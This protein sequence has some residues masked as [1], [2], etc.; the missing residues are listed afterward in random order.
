M[1]NDRVERRL[2]AVL[3]ADVVEYSRLMG[4]DEV[5][6][7]ARFNGALD[8]VIRPAIAGHQGRLVKT[9]GDGLLVEFASVVDAI[10]CAVKI[11]DQ[12][13]H[14]EKGK[15]NPMLLRIGVNLG[16]IIVEG[17]D[18][19]G[20]GVNIAARLEALA[21]PGGIC[22]SRSARDQVR[23]KLAY[24]IDDMGEVEVNN[25]ARP[26]RAFQI[27]DGPAEAT[28]GITRVATDSP[29]QAPQ[30]HRW[31]LVSAVAV[32]LAIAAAA[33]VWFE[34]WTPRV[35]AAS[36]DKM[37]FALPDKPSVA[38][39]PFDVTSNGDGDREF[40]DAVN[41]DLTRGLDRVSG[42][43]VIARSSTLGYVGEKASPAKVAEDLGVQHVVRASLRRA[44]NR[45]RIDAE[46]TDALSG[47]IIWSERFE[48]ASDDLFDL[49]D[50]LVQAL[51]IRM[52]H[53]LQTIDDQRRFT[54]D[55]EA[56]F[57][58]FTADSESW[59][60]NAVA[61]GK[62]SALAQGALERDPEFVRAKALLAFVD[63]QRAYFKQVD[64]PG[65]LLE[66]AYQAAKAA[67]EAAPGDWYTLATYGQTL[68]NKRDYL[69][70]V[71]QFERAIELDPSN[72]LL[73]TRSVL[74]LIFLGRGQEAEARLRIAVRLN[75][76]HNWLPD[77]LLGQSLYILERYKEAI[78]NLLIAKEKNPKFIGNLWWSAAA[79]GQM[80]MQV[81]AEEVVAEILKRMPNAAIS[82]SF[83]QIKD[84]QA[85]ARFTDGLRAAGLPE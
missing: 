66:S 6:T 81:E 72:T 41:E 44:G 18:I 3:S 61:Y 33:V 59:R 76:Y 37:Q 53:D 79:Y 77:Q 11:Q 9:M 78:E 84:E 10:D 49:Q 71:E 48:R 67:A 17:D 50:E 80:G 69:G 5:G 74:P 29:P 8:E 21:P 57:M 20:D 27:N 14:R 54:K 47:R 4:L 58:W 7:R 13:N 62:A 46:L 2:A 28:N 51:A 85:M 65:P 19:H 40:A 73:L 16:D 31:P 83:I 36:V 82:K 42:L 56:Y 35:E 24:R 75:P 60:N 23:D 43:F 52:A 32:G 63:T 26:V 25:I 38:V 15:A 34:P 64:D 30:R 45:V 1:A 39:L 22:I 12:L 55:V 70:A 68:M